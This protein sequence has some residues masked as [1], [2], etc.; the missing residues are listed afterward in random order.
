MAVTL[1]VAQ[2]DSLTGVAVSDADIALASSLIDNQTG[3]T[4]DEH[5]TERQIA[6]LSVQAAWAIVAGRVH[7]MLTDD[8]TGAITQESQGDYSY[9]E[10][11]TLA[12]TV[13]FSNIC[14]G[15]PAEL[16]NLHRAR[17]GHI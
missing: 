9:A 8:G 12:Q 4:P 5:A 11:V 3:S 15:R 1:S 6:V 14:D 7:R 13:H 2:V 17:W 16:L 10:S